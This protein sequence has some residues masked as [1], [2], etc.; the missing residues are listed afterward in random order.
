MGD[1]KAEIPTAIPGFPTKGK[2]PNK[3]TK[4]GLTSDIGFPNF[5]GLRICPFSEEVSEPTCLSSVS[6][7]HLTLPTTERV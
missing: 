4:A 1:S 3:K 6:Y 2:G 5:P 7:T